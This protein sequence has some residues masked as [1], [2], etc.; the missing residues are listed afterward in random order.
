M[1]PLIW[2]H[3]EKKGWKNEVLQIL[4]HLFISKKKGTN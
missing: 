4:Y 1:S 2:L 3:L